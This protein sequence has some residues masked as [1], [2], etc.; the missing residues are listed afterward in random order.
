MGPQKNWPPYESYNSGFLGLI[1]IP[2]LSRLKLM[3][4][5]VSQQVDSFVANSFVSELLRIPK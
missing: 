3:E 5:E 4:A 1:R 2:T